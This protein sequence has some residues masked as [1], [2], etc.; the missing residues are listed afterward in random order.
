VSRSDG[1]RGAVTSRG[2]WR[3]IGASGGRG[4][5][6]NEPGT[7]SCDRLD[8]KAR[9]RED[10]WGGFRVVRDRSLNFLLPDAVQRVAVRQPARACG[11]GRS[12][13]RLRELTDSP[14]VVGFAPDG[15]PRA[16]SARVP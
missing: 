14:A 1:D 9:G 16:G 13:P 5:G 3:E 11:S 10:G 2:S 7:V 4:T 15:N 6:G 8:G 12:P